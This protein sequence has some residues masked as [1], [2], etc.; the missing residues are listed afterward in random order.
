M[1]QVCCAKAVKIVVP[2]PG[3]LLCSMFNLW[4]ERESR[5]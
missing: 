3:S 2:L 5:G 4:R 1:G